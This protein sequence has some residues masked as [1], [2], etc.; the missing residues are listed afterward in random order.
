MKKKIDHVQTE[1]V[2]RI[3]L[4]PFFDTSYKQFKRTGYSIEQGENA[5][6]KSLC[7]LIWGCLFYRKSLK[8]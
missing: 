3:M 8:G 7:L 4:L 1:E 6:A 5:T 2:A